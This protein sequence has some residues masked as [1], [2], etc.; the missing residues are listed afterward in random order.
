ME[1]FNVNLNSSDDEENFLSVTSITGVVYSSSNVTSEA[2]SWTVGLQNH[3]GSHDYSSC[4]DDLPDLAEIG[5][6][7]IAMGLLFLVIILLAMLGNLLVIVSVLRTKNLRRQKAY[8]F[9]VSLAMADL[10]VSVGAMVFNAIQVILNGHWLFS[11]WLCD[12]YNAMDVV[13]STA[14]ILNLFCISM[15]RWCQIVAFPESYR[16]YFSRSV[17]VSIIIG[18][19]ILSFIIAF[20]PIFTNI[21]TTQQFL[22][23]R[24]PCKCDFVVNEWYCLVSSSI[25]FWLPSAGIVYF[26][27]E[28]TKCAVE[29]SQ[30]D[31]KVRRSTCSAGSAITQYSTNSSCANQ[32]LLDPYSSPGSGAHTPRVSNSSQMGTMNRNYNV[33]PHIDRNESLRDNINAAKTLVIILIVFFVCWFPFFLTYILSFV[34][35]LSFP[36]GWTSFVFWLGYTNSSI[37]PFIYAVKFKEFRPAFKDTLRCILCQTKTPADTPR[38]TSTSTN[39]IF[40]VN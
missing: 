13:F 39:I 7:G 19:W 23:A 20:V 31:A 28:I 6:Q 9:V 16:E 12:M 3:N 30:A 34:G 17:V 22:E 40:K 37:N 36:D 14:S 15:Y 33:S 1:K 29:K 21:Y 10:S 4:V 25:S 2:E 24:T 32:V 38:W 5:L 26:Y 8:Y 27:Y 35:K 18:I 11:M